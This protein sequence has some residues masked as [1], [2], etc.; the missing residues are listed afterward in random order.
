M[1]LKD[2]NS[3]VFLMPYS[4][5]KNVKYIMLS[6]TADKEICEYC[7]KDTEVRF[8]ECKTA[9]Y[10]G[11]LNQYYEKSMSRSCI[12][13][14]PKI[15]NKIIAWSKI[16]NIITFK[17]Y[18]VGKYY[19]GTA[20]GCDDLNGQ[21]L[22]VIGTPY[23][24]DFIYKLFAFT[25]GCEID[26]NAEME[27]CLVKYNG[28]QFHFTT[29]GEKHDILRKIQ[30]WMIESNLE[31]AVGRARLLR[32]GC[33]V[34]LFSNFPLRQAVMNEYTNEL[35]KIKLLKANKT[36]RNETTFENPISENE[37]I[38]TDGISTSDEMM[39]QFLP[40]VFKNEV[41]TDKIEE[42]T[43]SKDIIFMSFMSALLCN[44]TIPERAFLDFNDPSIFEYGP[45]FHKCQ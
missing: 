32:N 2:K 31:Q 21:D 29:Y 40:P 4:F 5:N 10:E 14:N 35:R 9:K 38:V 34:N 36:E 33:T 23:G 17:R 30:F 13:N 27:P 16:E 20:I 12:N 39:T 37:T 43:D 11:H 3:I 22:N 24:I 18:K 45:P 1:Y 7:V 41:L 26:E 44:G 28:Y 8:T 15:L 25:F 19:F 42:D 6:A